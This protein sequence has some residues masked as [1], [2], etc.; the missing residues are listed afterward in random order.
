MSAPRLSARAVL[1]PMQLIGLALA[2]S[3]L[4]AQPPQLKLRFGFDEASGTTSSD[5]VASATLRLLDY[6]GAPIDRHG[7]AGS[8]VAGQAN[9][10]RALD[11]SS[12]LGQGTNGPVA[13]LTNATLGF[14]EVSAFTATIWFKAR[15][16]QPANIGPRMFLLGAADTTSD[17]G[18]TNSIGLKFQTAACLHFQLNKVTAEADFVWSLPTNQWTFVAMV[19]DGAK[20]IV[21]RGTERTPAELI[22]AKAAPA[23]VVN[24]G[25]NVAL[26]IGNRQDR[27]RSFDGWLD[28][29]RFYT[30]AADPDFVE[31]IRQS[32]VGT[33]D[34][35][36]SAPPDRSS[37]AA[38]EWVLVTAPAF[39]TAM[40]PL[41]E[42]RRSQGF[43]VTLLQ[44]TNVLT[45]QQI[46]AGNAAPLKDHLQALFQHTPARKYL[47]LLAGPAARKGPHPEQFIVPMPLGTTARMKGQPTDY[48]YSLPD[49]AG[50]PTVAIG[51]FP[52]RTVEEMQTMVAKT[53]KLEQSPAAG[54]WRN[55]LLL[56]QGSPG[57]G[58]LAEM[59]ADGMAKPRLGRLH[60]AWRFKSVSHN[61]GSLYYVP[62]ASLQPLAAEYM[63]EGQLFS[64]YLGHSN[65]KGLWSNGTNFLSSADWSSLNVQSRQPVF[66]TCGCFACAADRAQEQAYGLAAI[67][68]PSG[69]VAVIGAY[70]ES[71]AA[72]GLLAADG[73]LRCCSDA[74]FPTRLADYWL[75]VQRGLAEGEIDGFMFNLMD[76]SDGTQG[77]VPLPVQRVEHLE[78]WTLLGDPALRLPIVPLAI[79]LKATAELRPG[80]SLKLEGKLPKRLKDAK[81]LLSLERIAG[82]RPADLAPLLAPAD[83][84]RITVE[85]NRKV[86]Q[87][88][89]ATA[90]ATADGASFTCSLDIP[91]K[92]DSLVIVVRAY[93]DHGP[94]AA[95]GVL[96]L[97][98]SAAQ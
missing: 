41:V 27:A 20:I 47:L 70:G 7:A 69:P 85:N 64:V 56:M 23:Q 21:Y 36:P 51:R 71:Y 32:A 8:G 14:D 29:F 76:M 19:Y 86:N 84:D 52:A 68:N 58:P 62:T 61:S 30:G 11:F 4:A 49:E 93:A 28:D 75:A 91:E 65:G 25:T 80:K 2:I 87:T 55:G 37:P 24:V 54:L 53:L 43:K 79:S 97:P 34:N 92:L 46:C 82:A 31:S 13:A 63:T 59:F 9:A 60:P 95:Q 26:F 77:Q 42:H 57:G 81:V 10:N 67:R 6:S 96:K 18:S 12:A 35:A 78:M 44:T 50:R 72:P 48:G 89:L 15:S 40:A 90:T 94:D 98:V 45:D 74:P 3:G 1:A 38:G 5:T 88:T 39:S 83:R 16:R 73:L 33:P 17:T 22:A 66:F